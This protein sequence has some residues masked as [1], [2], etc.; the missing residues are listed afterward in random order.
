MQNDDDDDVHLKK[1]E[2]SRI[3]ERQK[4]MDWSDDD[5]NHWYHDAHQPP[6]TQP[7]P[8][9]PKQPLS[10]DDSIPTKR[11]ATHQP[12][13]TYATITK[14]PQAT[15]NQVSQILPLH[16]DRHRRTVILRRAPYG[17]TPHDII[18]ALQGQFDLDR[19]NEYIDS[20]L[21]AKMTDDVTTLLSAHTST[22][23]VSPLKALALVILPFRIK[24]A[25]C[26]H[27]YRNRRITLQKTAYITY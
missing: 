24:Q 13:V 23:G 9:H 1:H 7:P 22:N 20:I 10:E 4:Q 8:T 14:P 11:Q 3:T 26:R 5:N 19:P 12:S 6:P 25:M 18:T 21:Q 16:A 17:T 2:D 15:Q 27:T